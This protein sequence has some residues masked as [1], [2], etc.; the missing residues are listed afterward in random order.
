M[1][2][3]N[4]KLVTVTD[5]MFKTSEEAKVIMCRVVFYSMSTSALLS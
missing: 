5:C 2:A 1:I 4:L 3:R